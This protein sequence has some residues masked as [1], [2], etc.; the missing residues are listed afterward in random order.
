MTIGTFYD[1]D[2]ISRFSGLRG[3]EMGRR[4]GDRV[5]GMSDRRAGVANRQAGA[6]VA[7]GSVAGKGIGKANRFFGWLRFIT[8]VWRMR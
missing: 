1:I 2:H 7:F 3:T 4:E 8:F 5:D 6:G